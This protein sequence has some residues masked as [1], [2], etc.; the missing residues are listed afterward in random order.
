MPWL[1]PELGAP[2]YLP[3]RQPAVTWGF[4]TSGGD[5]YDVAPFT[6]G[7]RYYMPVV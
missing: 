3:G 2:P 4:S 7:Y 6:V 1:Y 5:S